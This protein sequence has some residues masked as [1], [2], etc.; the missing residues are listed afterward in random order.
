MIFF[1]QICFVL[2]HEQVHLALT[3]LPDSVSV[4]WATSKSVDSSY[5]SFGTSPDSLKKIEATNWNYEA[6]DLTTYLHSARLRGL[7]SKGK[8]YYQLSDDSNSQSEMFSFIA[9]SLEQ[10]PIR[11]LAWGDMGTS[12]FQHCTGGSRFDNDYIASLENPPNFILHVGDIAYD[13]GNETV[14]NVFF[15]EIQPYA[16]HIPYMTCVG[17]E[18]H[19]YNF[20]GY[21]NRFVMPSQAEGETVPMFYSFDYSFVHV[22]SISTEAGAEPYQPGTQQYKWLV[23]DLKKAH[24][25]PN[26]PW[27][28]VI[29]HR[30]MYCSSNDYYD[31][32]MWGPSVR[33]IF[34]PIFQKYNVDLYLSGHVHSYERT[35]HVYNGTV[36]DSG[37]THVMIG[38]GGAGLTHKWTDP[39]P[40]WSVERIIAYG[41]VQLDVGEH[42]L[43]FQLLGTQ[44]GT[45]TLDEFTL[46]K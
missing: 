17:N 30:P 3:E 16:N 15:N 23:N 20:S 37:T 7:K 42:A 6:D 35:T 5:V 11:I 19:A 46:E 14:W 22:V 18:D 29:G 1:L 27:I 2:G 32:G 34:E 39:K 21:R 36:Q 33:E 12:D 13:R 10:E 44:N 41:L 4:T 40:E 8:Y 24:A 25:N 43:N 26:T 28:I 45:N 31:C 38:M 9:P